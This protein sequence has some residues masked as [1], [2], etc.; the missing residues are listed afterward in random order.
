MPHIL[1]VDDDS[2]TR[3]AL[4]ALADALDVTCDTAAS[5]DEARACLAS[6]QP[7]L[8]LCD[9]MLPDGSGMLLFD[10]APPGCDFVVATGHASLDSAIS[11][12]RA[13]ATDYLVKPLDIE[14]LRQLLS[15]V[16]LRE[17]PVADVAVL[18]EELKK[19]GRFG[20]MLG[21]SAAMLTVY[22]S[23]AR[24]A[25]TDASVLLTGESGT[26]KE[27]AAQTIHEFS[28]RRHGA[29]V[30]INCGAVPPNLIES[31]MFG[32]ERGSF[33]GAE[34]EHKGFFERA[35]GGT[36][37]LDEIT[38][39][40]TDLQVRFLR[41]LETER[42]VRL[43][44]T[45]EIDVD[46]RIIAATNRDPEASIE[47]GA[48]RADLYHRINVYPIALPP[49]RERGRDVALLANAFLAKINEETGG[50]LV[51]SSAAI[52][53][54]ESRQWRGNVRE[55]RNL[56]Q[57]AAIFCSGDVIDSLPPPVMEELSMGATAGDKVV[58]VPLGTPLEEMDRRLISAT[59]AHHGGVKSRAAE[60]LDVSLKTIYNRLAN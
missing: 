49:L 54:L 52:A 28:D 40:P 22:D 43:G 33:T 1:V 46:V 13:G 24:V 41:V 12:I 10:S 39:M 14:R 26:G 30:G 6:R 35:H 8:I 60:T 15:R 16:S 45:R 57:R 56:V 48:L 55:L 25:A 31:E 32:H 38:E 36:L 59:L 37:F 20:R 58:T 23:I 18:A 19:S 27:V 44:G 17:S 51:F 34:R 11:A 50:R 29:F 7:D 4:A 2:E 47:S 9:L 5:I 42:I 53:D 3:A 21:N